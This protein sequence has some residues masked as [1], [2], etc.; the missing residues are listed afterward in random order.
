MPKEDEEICLGYQA[1]DHGEY[2]NIRKAWFPS[3]VICSICQRDSRPLAG[4][5]F[6]P[7]F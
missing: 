5:P 7:V 2:S 3:L 6:L 4:L 1:L